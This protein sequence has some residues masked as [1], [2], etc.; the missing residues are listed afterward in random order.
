LKD[1]KIVWIK[2]TYGLTRKDRIQKCEYLIEE[3]QDL[4]DI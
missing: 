2:T 4:L 3:L 1:S